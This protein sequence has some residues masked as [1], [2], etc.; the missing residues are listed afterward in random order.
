M[1]DF[2][3]SPNSAL[4]NADYSYI[5]MIWR[6]WQQSL[7][8]LKDERINAVQ[9]LLPWGKTARQGIEPSAYVNY[10]AQLP[11]TSNVQQ[12]RAFATAPTSAGEKFNAVEETL[13]VYG[14]LSQKDIEDQELYQGAMN[15]TQKREEH[16]QLAVRLLGTPVDKI[17]AS[18][19]TS[20][21]VRFKLTPRF[22]LT[23]ETVNYASIEEIAETCCDEG[24]VCA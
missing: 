3:H 2:E 18:E 7:N 20:Q 22:I 6:E 15:E 10:K 23:A 14:I 12:D 5:D 21:N 19:A 4:L 16:A 17:R 24:L 13:I 9:V 11:V 8:P 1:V